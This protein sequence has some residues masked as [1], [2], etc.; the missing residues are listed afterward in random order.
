MDPYDA[1]KC[2][3]LRQSIEKIPAYLINRLINKLIDPLISSLIIYITDVHT[4]IFS[5]IFFKSN[6]NKIVF[7]IF[8]DCFGT[9]NRQYPFA[10]PN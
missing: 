5:R 1:E 4:E 10:V 2:Q 9:A 8:L 6:R 3:P 7:T